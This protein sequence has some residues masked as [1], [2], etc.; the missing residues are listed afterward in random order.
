VA[1]NESMEMYLET[2]Y[3]LEKSEGHAHSVDISKKLGVTKAS[4]TKATKNLKQAGYIVKEPYG[5]ITLT[6]KGRAL[7]EEVYR[8]H[9][10]IKF[11]LIE[12]LEVSSKDAADNACR[13]EHVLTKTVIDA[14]EAF[15]IKR[16]KYEQCEYS[17]IS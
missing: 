11:F 13:L 3:L 9:E 5:S 12:T 8:K 17:G 7:S 10:L 4:V 2:I 16:G 14:I 6:D 15:L 1:N